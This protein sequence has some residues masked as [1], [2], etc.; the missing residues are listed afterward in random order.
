MVALAVELAE[1]AVLR[2]LETP[3]SVTST[4]ANGDELAHLPVDEPRR[5]V[6]AVAAAGAV[7]EHHVVERRACA[8]S[9]RALPPR[10]SARSRAERAFFSCGSTVSAAAVRVPGRGE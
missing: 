7:D 1:E 4:A 3:S 8:A 9:A 2:Q 10:E 6:V 5:V